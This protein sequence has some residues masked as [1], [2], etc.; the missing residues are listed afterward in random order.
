MLSLILVAFLLLK[1][2]TGELEDVLLSQDL[3]SKFH[4]VK[5]IGDGDSGKAY[6][7][8]FHGDGR[9]VAIKMVDRR[10]QQ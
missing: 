8:T 9:D 2:A 1:S 3:S 4:L 5:S 7:A 10:E 6:R